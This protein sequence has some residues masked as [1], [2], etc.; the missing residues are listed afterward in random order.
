MDRHLAL[1]MLTVSKRSRHKMPQRSTQGNA[2]VT[3]EREDV[4][5]PQAIHVISM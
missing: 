2:E 3:E 1:T 4:T 5:L